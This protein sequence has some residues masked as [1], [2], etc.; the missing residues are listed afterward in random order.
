[1]FLST[2]LAVCAYNQDLESSI[3]LLLFHSSKLNFIFKEIPM[4][5]IFKASILRS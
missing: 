2:H 5:K 3:T 1:M 4:F